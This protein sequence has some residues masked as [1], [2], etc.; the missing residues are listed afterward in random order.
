MDRKIFLFLVL[1]I[2]AKLSNAQ[3]LVSDGSGQKLKVTLNNSISFIEDKTSKLT[4]D[5]V[6][7]SAAFVPVGKGR[8]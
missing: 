2:T 6:R 5:E 3:I 4:F 7:K 8:S 1:L